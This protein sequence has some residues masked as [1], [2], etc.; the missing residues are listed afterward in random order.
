MGGELGYHAH[1]V[2]SRQL[3]QAIEPTATPAICSVL[4]R[5][6]NK[7]SKQHHGFANCFC[8]S[9]ATSVLLPIVDDTSCST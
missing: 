3:L 4:I 9:A 5:D 1:C 6:I 8:Y 2:R 7:F